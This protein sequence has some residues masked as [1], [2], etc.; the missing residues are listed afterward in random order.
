MRL[1]RP[2]Y[3]A[4]SYV[5]DALLLLVMGMAVVTLDWRWWL[6]VMPG[7]LLVLVLLVIESVA[8]FRVRVDEWRNRA[9]RSVFTWGSLV[10]WGLAWCVL[11]FG[12]VSP[13]SMHMVGGRWV[14]SPGILVMGRA[15]EMKAG[16]PAVGSW[17]LV[18]Q[19]GVVVPAKI[20][21]IGRDAG[22][23]PSTYECSIPNYAAP[24]AAKPDFRP[25]GVMAGSRP[26]RRSVAPSDVV[27]TRVLLWPP[28]F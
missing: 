15:G 11:H 24:G 2:G 17:I 28:A 23:A 14:P 27:S 6:A 22:G 18:R 10:A 5:A 8:V 3:G 7:A 19:E 26:V 13:L 20:V 25:P 4:V 16:Q 9:A 1:G 12:F 21:R